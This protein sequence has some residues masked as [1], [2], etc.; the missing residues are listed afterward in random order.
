MSLLKIH[1]KI[2]SLPMGSASL[3]VE[4]FLRLNERDAAGISP[5]HV[6]F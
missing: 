5:P 2:G 1:D 6:R 4:A 3:T